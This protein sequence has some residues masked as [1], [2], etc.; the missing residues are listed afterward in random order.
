M[1]DLGFLWFREFYLESSRV[2]QVKNLDSAIITVYCWELF[3][4]SGSWNSWRASLIW[5]VVLIWNCQIFIS[6]FVLFCNDWKFLAIVNEWKK[7]KTFSLL[8]CTWSGKRG[9]HRKQTCMQN[10]LY[11]SYEEH[12]VCLDSF[13][14]FIGLNGKGL[15]TWEI[16]QFCGCFLLQHYGVSD[17]KECVH[18]SKI[19]TFPSICSLTSFFFLGS[20][21][22]MCICK[23]SQMLHKAVLD[24]N[25]VSR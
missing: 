21:R 14:A 25:K 11:C 12:W 4:F 20:Y 1:T 3:N 2:I 6:V 22:L 19:R 23:N 16:L 17:V 13:A 18:F 5:S 8:L 7:K 24:L 9:A 15:M 10:D